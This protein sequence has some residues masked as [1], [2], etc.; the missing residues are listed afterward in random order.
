MTKGVKIIACLILAVLLCLPGAAQAAKKKHKSNPAKAKAAAATVA[1]P[2]APQPTS[3]AVLSLKETVY[4]SGVVMEGPPIE[5]VFEVQNP[6]KEALVIDSVRPGCGCTVARFDRT[7]PPGGSGKIVLT[8][9]SKKVHGA[10]TKTATVSSND[11]DHPSLR[12]TLR[13]VVKKLVEVEPQRLFLRGYKDEQPK[14]T[15]KIRSNLA[16]PLVIKSVSAEGLDGKADYQLKTLQ[17]GKDY[18]VEILNRAGV[19]RYNGKL[20]LKTNSARLPAIEVQVYADITGDVG[21]FPNTLE[22]GRL[23]AG[24]QGQPGQVVTFWKNRGPDFQ[25][26]KVTYNQKRFDVEVRQQGARYM[27]YVRPRMENLKPG[28]IRDE[29]RIET[30]SADL[31]EVVVPIHGWIQ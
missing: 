4:D 29:V 12:L 14:G 7:I 25:V 1:K 8:L 3:Q 6:G 11:T 16:E 21:Y 23:S 24:Q 27:V 20:V 9:D 31:P 28:E 15:V 2:P 10:Y 17:D 18:Q 30:T 13:G 5:H 22:M 19:G 26:G